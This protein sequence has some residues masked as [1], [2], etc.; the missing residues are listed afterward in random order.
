MD[1]KLIPVSNHG[2]FLLLGMGQLV[3]RFP[4]NR[5]NKTSYNIIPTNITDV[6]NKRKSIEAKQMKPQQTQVRFLTVRPPRDPLS[7]GLD[8]PNKFEPMEDNTVINNQRITEVRTPRG[9][10]VG[11]LD[12]R[13]GT[14]QIKDGKRIT[15][16]EIPET[17]LNIRFASADGVFEQ[18]RVALPEEKHTT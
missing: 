13:T 17:G 8:E 7:N 6:K 2:D 18:I 4:T 10:M 14:L 16:I 15:V 9:K 11:A 12:A 1:Y 5:T 3:I